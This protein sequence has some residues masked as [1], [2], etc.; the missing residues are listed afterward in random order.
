MGLKLILLTILFLTDRLIKYLVLDTGRY[1]LNEGL[2]LGILKDSND[3]YVLVLLFGLIFVLTYLGL[4]RWKK[5]DVF[6]KLAML[7]IILGSL[8]N[9]MDRIM[10]NGVIDYISLL[11]FP[12]FNIADAMIVVGIVYLFI[13]EYGT[14]DNKANS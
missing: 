5:H 11:R 1:T 7:S 10:Y 2:A 12:V 9:L 6:S 8:S 14:K 3:N 13:K 4:T